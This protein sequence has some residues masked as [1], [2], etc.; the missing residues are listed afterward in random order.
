MEFGS[1]MVFALKER[2]KKKYQH[3]NTHQKPLHSNQPPFPFLSVSIVLVPH[4]F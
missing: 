3:K 2:L 4:I 1:Q